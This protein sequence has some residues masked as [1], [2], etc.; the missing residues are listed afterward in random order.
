MACCKVEIYAL[1][2][3]R[4]K[5]QAAGPETLFQ[6]QVRSDTKRTIELFSSNPRMVFPP[7]RRDRNLQVLQ[8]KELTNLNIGVKAQQAGTQRVRIHCVDLN[9]R[10]LVQAWLLELE[11][12]KPLLQK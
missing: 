6:L 10:E 7:G 12:D 4:T 2:C 1:Q 11:A 9:T 5:L 8:P 3:I